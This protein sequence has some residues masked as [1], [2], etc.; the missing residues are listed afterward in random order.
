[1]WPQS[2][3]NS[4]I[5]AF[6]TPAN[7]RAGPSAR[8]VNVW[9]EKPVKI[10]ARKFD[11]RCSRHKRYNPA[12]DG[13]GAI[14]G[15]CPRCTLMFEIWEASL[16]LNALIRRFDPKHDDLKRRVEKVPAVDPRQMSLIVD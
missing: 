9:C 12:V 15:A 3:S 13:P 8:P 7:S 14:R 10:R 16:H 2:L 11:G 4:T 6:S 5:D 1:M